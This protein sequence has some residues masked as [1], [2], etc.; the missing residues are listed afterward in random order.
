MSE[1]WLILSTIHPCI[2][3]IG[4]NTES[5]YCALQ[6]SETYKESRTIGTRAERESR[7]GHLG[8]REHF[9]CEILVI[10]GS[11]WSPKH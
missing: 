11:K 1:D 2:F 5:R 8:G 4:I 10:Q 9:T 7:C 6:V 3:G